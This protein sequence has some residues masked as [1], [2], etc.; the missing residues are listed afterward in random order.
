MFPIF[1]IQPALYFFQNWIIAPDG[2]HAFYCDGECQFPLAAHMNAT[3][4]NYSYTNI[5]IDVQYIKPMK[6]DFTKR[7]T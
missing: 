2:F 3:N 7:G 6:E 1:S 5:N 4:L